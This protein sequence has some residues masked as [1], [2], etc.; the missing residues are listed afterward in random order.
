MQAVSTESRSKRQ[1]GSLF[2]IPFRTL[3]VD[4][5]PRVNETASY[6]NKAKRYVFDI[7]HRPVRWTAQNPSPLA[8]LF[9]PILTRLLWEAFSHVA[10]IVRRLSTHI[11][12]QLSRALFSF[13]HLTELERKWE[14]PKRQQRGFEPVLPPIASPAFYNRS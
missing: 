4:S 3:Q 9:T 5:R 12:P 6:H 11:F 14:V 7:A 2:F 1:F 10:I 8:E 13:L